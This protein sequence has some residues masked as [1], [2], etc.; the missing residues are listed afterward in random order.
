MGWN[1]LLLTTGWAWRAIT[2]AMRKKTKFRNTEILLHYF[3]N[4]L[5]L[6]FKIT[7]SI[8]SWYNLQNECRKRIIIIFKKPFHFRTEEKEKK[9]T[10]LII[11]IFHF[12]IELLSQNVHQLLCFFMLL[13]FT[14]CL[15]VI[16]WSALVWNAY[17]TQAKWLQTFVT[18]QK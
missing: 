2:A 13:I 9:K 17:C 16:P 12:V 15:E 11:R 14:F 10:F 6:K 1:S 18:E 7:F 4:L 3:S 8:P 5:I